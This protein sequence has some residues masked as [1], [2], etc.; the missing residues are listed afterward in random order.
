MITKKFSLGRGK[1]TLWK[2]KKK[3]YVEIDP[4]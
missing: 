2:K 3:R 4:A 1:L